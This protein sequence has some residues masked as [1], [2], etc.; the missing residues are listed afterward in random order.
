VKPSI[1]VIVD[2]LPPPDK[3]KK[4][5]GDDDP[6][7]DGGDEGNEYNAEEDAAMAVAKALGVDTAKVDVPALCEALKDFQA[8]TRG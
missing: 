4:S 3:L 7:A 6:A 2:K 1:D 5:G 8:T